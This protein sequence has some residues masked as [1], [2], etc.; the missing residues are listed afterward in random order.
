MM[1]ERAKKNH[2]EY[3]EMIKVIDYGAFGIVYKGKE[4]EKDELRA[5]KVIDHIMEIMK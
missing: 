1:E 5:I 4:R 2:E 3:Y